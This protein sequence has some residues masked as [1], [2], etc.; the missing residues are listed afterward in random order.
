M[1]VEILS[2]R[3]YGEPKLK[4]PPEIVGLK[5]AGSAKFGSKCKCPVFIQ[6]NSV[7]VKHR[8][9]FSAYIPISVAENIGFIDRRRQKFI[10][11]DNFGSVVLRNEAWLK[12]N[13]LSVDKS[14]IFTHEMVNKLIIAT[15]DELGFDWEDIYHYD[16][17]KFYEDIINIVKEYKN[18]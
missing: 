7:Y 11:N 14:A 9:W 10:Y 15:A 16:W 3:L 12:I 8:D 1:V 18:D 4:K 6:D 17:V 13:D 5:Q 2:E